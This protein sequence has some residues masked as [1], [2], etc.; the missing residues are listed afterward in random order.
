MTKS[1][2][3]PSPFFTLEEARNFFENPAL[4]RVMKFA[5]GISLSKEGF[6]F[7]GVVLGNPKNLS[8]VSDDLYFSLLV[9]KII[10]D[11]AQLK[12]DFEKLYQKLGNTN[13]QDKIESVV[14][15]LK[16]ED[17]IK[18][19]SPIIVNGEAAIVPFKT[20]QD[21][22]DNSFGNNFKIENVLKSGL[23]KK[24]K[25]FKDYINALD[26]HNS[27]NESLLSKYNEIATDFDE[28]LGKLKLPIRKSFTN[29]AAEEKEIKNNQKRGK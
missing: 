20:K 27:A 23:F 17:N 9:I 6:Y 22:D 21:Y 1:T 8:T 15:S 4:E 18:S 28:V 7:E 16:T 14:R 11:E 10:C 29:I 13:E 5:E 3:K 12:K 24:I 26:T 25:H 19:V 2:K